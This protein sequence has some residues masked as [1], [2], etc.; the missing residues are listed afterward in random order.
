MRTGFTCVHVKA[1]IWQPKAVAELAL[2]GLKVDTV[3]DIRR[4]SVFTVASMMGGTGVLRPECCSV[5]CGVAHTNKAA[6]R[7]ALGMTAE[8]GATLAS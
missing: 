7:T 3:D 2:T 8:Y 6:L 1:L 5:V 4:N